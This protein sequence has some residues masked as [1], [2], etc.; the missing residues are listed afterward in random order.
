MLYLSLESVLSEFDYYYCRR[1]HHKHHHHVTIPTIFVILFLH[2]CFTFLDDRKSKSLNKFP[3]PVS[4]PL[5]F[6]PFYLWFSTIYTVFHNNDI[7]S[8]QQFLIKFSGPENRGMLVYGK[9]YLCIRPWR[10]MEPWN[11]EAPT[12]S[13]QSAHNGR[14]IVIRRPLISMKFP[15]T[16]FS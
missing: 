13:R 15:G 1:H 4:S 7:T 8:I 12:F 5:L 14:E 9:S 6:W 16:H 10:P 3:F 11:V 2:L